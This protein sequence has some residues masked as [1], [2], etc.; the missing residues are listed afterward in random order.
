MARTHQLSRLLAFLLLNV[1][2]FAP[3]GALAVGPV[4][5]DGESILIS[6]IG[7]LNNQSLLWGPYRPNLY[8]GI[9]P[10]IPKSLMAGLM[11]G[12][13]ETYTDYQNSELWNHREC[14]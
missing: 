10:R 14:M 8:F 6:E 5:E 1:L 3:R 9:R 4:V 11:W 7:R 13:I 12:K 2:S